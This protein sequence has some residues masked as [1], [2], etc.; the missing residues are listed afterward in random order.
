VYNETGSLSAN[1]KAKPGADGSTEQLHQA[2]VEVA[3]VAERVLESKHPGRVQADDTLSN[4]T[5]HDLAGGN[6]KVIAALKDSRSAA[7]SALSGSNRSRSDAL[8][9]FAP[10]DK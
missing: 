5:L 4:Q 8:S 7:E 3:E 6:K 10:Y 1:S 9:D 2:R